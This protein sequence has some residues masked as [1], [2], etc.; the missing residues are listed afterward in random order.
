MRNAF[1]GL[2]LLAHP[3]L[4]L[5]ADFASMFL[6]DG[7]NSAPPYASVYSSDGTRFFAEP[8]ERMQERLAASQQKV[9]TEF[10]E[11][12]DHLSVMLEY[13][14]IGFEAL[15]EEAERPEGAEQ[16][17]PGPALSEIK[18]FI[19][20]ELLSWLPAFTTRCGQVNTVSDVYPA[21]ALLLFEFCRTLQSL[22]EGFALDSELEH[23][24]PVT[25]T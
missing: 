21:L 11:P 6:L 25:D 16:P 4:E 19:D 20:A 24:I 23:K 9:S 8:Q 3:R 10:R 5:A 7:K 1:N 14:G 15:I 12:S 2:T 17:T 22:D 18:T 13:L